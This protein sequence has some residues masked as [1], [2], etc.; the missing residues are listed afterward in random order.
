MFLSRIY[1]S[2]ATSAVSS[3]YIKYIDYDTH[4]K[5]SLRPRRWNYY[6]SYLLWDIIQRLAGAY[7]LYVCSSFPFVIATLPR[8]MRNIEYE[9]HGNMELHQTVTT[10][11]SSR[12]CCRNENACHSWKWI[13]NGNGQNA[14]TS[15]SLMNPKFL[16]Q[17]SI[18]HFHSTD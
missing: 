15:F 16:V 2:N 8:V 11:I 7:I 18:I 17:R 10:I 13:L 6:R 12:G 14:S 4:T 1:Q 3:T 5:A 9:F